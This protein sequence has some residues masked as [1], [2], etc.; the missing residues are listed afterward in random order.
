MSFSICNAQNDS[1]QQYKD[2]KIGVIPNLSSFEHMTEHERYVDTM[3]DRANKEILK[4]M[5]NGS[6]FLKGT[7]LKIKKESIEKQK[8]A[9][10]TRI[11]DNR[12]RYY[13]QLFLNNEPQPPQYKDI[14]TLVTP[15]DCE[16]VNDT[17]KVRMGVWVFGGFAFALDIVGNK[18][19]SR[20][21]ED[22]HKQKIY[23]SRMQDSLLVDN[24]EVPNVTQELILDKTPIYK[25]GQQLTGYLSFKTGYYFRSA[26]YEKEIEYEYTDKKMDTLYIKGILYFKCKVH[27]KIY[28]DL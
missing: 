26:D 10:D 8:I 14:D 21:W 28:E 4:S 7:S 5:I 9:V 19:T 1:S 17:I 6:G 2:F 13:F 16:V 20:Y 3:M 24:V 22:T 27:K 11:K 25:L 23:K 18:F 15:C 12:S